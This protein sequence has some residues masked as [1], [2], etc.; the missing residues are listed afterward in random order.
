M[1]QRPEKF[2]P[3][4]KNTNAS[5]LT[6]PSMSSSKSVGKSLSLSFG[7]E[8]RFHVQSS[9]N[10]SSRNMAS[11]SSVRNYPDCSEGRMLVRLVKRVKRLVIP[12]LRLR[13]R[14]T[15][16][17]LHA[18]PRGRRLAASKIDNLGTRKG[19]GCR[20]GNGNRRIRR[21]ISG[22]PAGKWRLLSRR[23]RLLSTCR[24]R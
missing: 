3:T 22:W 8:T 17:F 1:P 19:G 24:N 13:L 4:Q 7:K 9:P 5:S 14:R 16:G 21:R 12:V 6:T 18:L 10:I 11:E 23:G 2:A 20:S 15:D